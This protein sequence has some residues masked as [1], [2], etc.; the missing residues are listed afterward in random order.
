MLRPK[1]INDAI[2]GT[3]KIDGVRRELLSTPELNFVP[4]LSIIA[5][6]VCA[7]DQSS[8]ISSSV[9]F[10]LQENKNKTSN[11]DKKVFVKTII[12]NYCIGSKM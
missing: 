8:F 4:D 5:P 12:C 1:V 6:V 11:T 10:L 2:H 3:Y 7:F 9:L